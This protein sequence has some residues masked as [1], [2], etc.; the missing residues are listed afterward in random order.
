MS[1][2]PWHVKLVFVAT[3]LLLSRVT[4]RIRVAEC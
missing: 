1:N 2:S 4:L 3:F